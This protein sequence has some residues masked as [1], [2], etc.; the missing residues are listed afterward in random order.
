[1]D[2]KYLG[3]GAYVEYNGYNFVL[4]TSNGIQDTNTIY[5]EPEHLDMLMD[6]AKRVY[7]QGR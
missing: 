6:Y 5:L 3:D 2:K 4:T 7:E 1:M